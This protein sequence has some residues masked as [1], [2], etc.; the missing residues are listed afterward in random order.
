VIGRIFAE[1]PNSQWA[2][3]WRV[4]SVQ[5]T[6]TRQSHIDEI[7]RAQSWFRSDNIFV[8]SEQKKT[9]GKPKTQAYL[10][11]KL[12]SLRSLGGVEAAWSFL[13][14][15]QTRD[16]HT[17]DN[18]HTPGTVSDIYRCLGP[19]PCISDAS[20]LLFFSTYVH[21]RSCYRRSMFGFG[22]K[23]CFN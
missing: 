12:E 23:C 18:K 13:L 1:S 5:N 17:L 3:M 20:C 16:V 19:Y 22:D 15:W 10:K 9:A 8:R 4:P 11:S 6:D 2:K 21:M 14:P 7:G